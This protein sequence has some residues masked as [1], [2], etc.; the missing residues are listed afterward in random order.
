MSNTRTLTVTPE[1]GAGTVEPTLTRTR[2]V[3]LTVAPRRPVPAEGAGPEVD[4]GAGDRVQRPG[5]QGGESRP[6]RDPLHAGGW[7]GD[8]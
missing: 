7:V 4:R 8:C 5:G 2:T 3:T 1:E 6:A